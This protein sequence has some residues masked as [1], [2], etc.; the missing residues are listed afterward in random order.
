MEIKC[1]C[2][3]SRS[4]EVVIL[5]EGMFWEVAANNALFKMSSL[6]GQMPA[7]A[8][9]VRLGV[10]NHQRSSLELAAAAL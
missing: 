7:G 1:S 9:D 10:A 3:K 8:L 2:R 5:Q 4:W 6:K